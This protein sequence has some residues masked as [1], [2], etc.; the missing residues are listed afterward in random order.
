MH[1]A[2]IR[3]IL[4]K[5]YD[6]YRDDVIKALKIL[7]P[8]GSLSG[9]D[10]GLD[11]VWEEFKY[12]VQREESGMFDLY[13]ETI[14]GVCADLAGKLPN[15]ELELLWLQTEA[16]FNHDEDDEPRTR[17]ELVEDVG[18]ELYGRVL[19]NAGDQELRFDPDEEKETAAFQ[20]DLE[21]FAQPHDDP[22]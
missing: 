2:E 4:Q 12:Q 17:D 10:S 9:D 13:V 8:E 11:D 6:A 19:E 14:E 18:H 3:D 7:P 15:H 21:L 22:N 20:Q 16:Y 1:R 5:K